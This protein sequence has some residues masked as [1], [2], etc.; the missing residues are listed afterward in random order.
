MI[1][2]ENVQKMTKLSLKQKIN[3]KIHMKEQTQ[4]LIKIH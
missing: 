4:D 3:F 1:S 2:W